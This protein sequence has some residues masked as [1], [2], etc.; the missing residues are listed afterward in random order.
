MDP[1]QQAPPPDP[2]PP[3]PVPD[4]PSPSAPTQKTPSRWLKIATILAPLLVSHAGIGAMTWA[5]SRPPSPTVRDL[6]LPKEVKGKPGELITI[7]ATTPGSKVSW[8]SLD[9]GL[10]LTTNLAELITAK[11]C[12]AVGVK[13]GRY[14]VECWTAVG[15]EPSAIVQ[16]I[17][18]ISEDA[19]GPP[20]PPGPTPGPSPPPAPAP[21]SNPL[22]VKLQAA[23]NADSAPLAAKRGQLAL[24]QGLYEA[25]AEHAKDTKLATARELLS[26]LQKAGGKMIAPGA[27]PEVRQVIAAEIAAALGDNPHAKL[28]PDI[29]PKAVSCFGRIA[30]SLS[31]VK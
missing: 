25:M 2:A 22:T 9:P 26:E 16:T 21:P 17:V 29:R 11:Q 14:R 20:G 5:V 31:E 13:P 12:I 4:S 24:L 30:Q 10:T 15:S 18:V 23:Y 8:R 28:D 27:L 3:T 19:A 7:Q 6:T 1:V